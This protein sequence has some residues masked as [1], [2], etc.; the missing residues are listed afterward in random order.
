MSTQWN[1][2]AT[3]TLEVAKEISIAAYQGVEVYITEN[4]VNFTQRVVARIGDRVVQVELNNFGIGNNE[5]VIHAIRKCTKEVL[6]DSKDQPRINIL[7]AELKKYKEVVKKMAYDAEMGAVNVYVADPRL[8]R[9]HA[10]V[11][12]A[13]ILMEHGT[14]HSHEEL[15]GVIDEIAGLQ[16]SEQFKSEEARRRMDFIM[17][18]GMKL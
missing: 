17:A 13:E 4:P 18:K 12:A 2:N 14:I 6:M 11:Q 16:P 3:S 15:L 10:L 5:D 9:T 1:M 7:E 8:A